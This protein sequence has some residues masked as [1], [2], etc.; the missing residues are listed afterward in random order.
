MEV[1][2]GQFGG[3][4]AEIKIIKEGVE[5]IAPLDDGPAFKAGLKQGDIITELD[6]KELKRLS[7][8]EIIQAVHGAPG[9]TLTLTLLREGKPLKDI[10]ITREMITDVPIKGQL[11]GRVAYIRLSVFNN[12]SAEHLKKTLDDLNKKLHETFG[13]AMTFQGVILDLRNNPGGT[14]DQAVLVTSL[15]LDKGSA[16]VNV[17]EKEPSSH[18]TFYAQGTDILKDIPIVVLINKG[19]ASASEV[20]AGALRDHKRAIL[21]GEKTYGKGSVQQIFDLGAKGAVK[22]TI[23]HFTTPDGHKIHGKGL[24]PDILVASE[25]TETP[26]KE[27]SSRDKDLKPVD[28][29]KQRALDLI[30][31]LSALNKW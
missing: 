25:P 27:P 21:V 31:G 23:A 9:T 16:I 8:V 12:Q 1:L 19:S 13:N 22:L 10:K 18:R 24:E 2:N 4:G 3:I 26:I 30:Q 15:F 6:G 17:T 11:D 29:Q 14:L 5:I 28:H 7:P 20:L